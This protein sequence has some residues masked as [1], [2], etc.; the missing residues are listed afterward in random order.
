MQNNT[1]NMSQATEYFNG[2]SLPADTWNSKYALTNLEDEQLEETPDDMHIRMAKYFSRISQEKYGGWNNAD[3]RLSDYGQRRDPLSLQKAYLL[4]RKF[5]NIIPQG[6]IMAG[7]GDRFRY[8]SL[9]NCVVIE[10]VVDSY[11]GIMY[12]DQQLAQLMKR[13]CGVGVDISNLRPRG[14]TT[15][16][17]AGTSTGAVSFLKSSGGKKGCSDGYS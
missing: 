13:R 4:F 17:A 5:K 7:L 10:D 8:K 16:N 1:N 9:S 11:G 15:R 6:S 12:S 2:N 14:S 3:F